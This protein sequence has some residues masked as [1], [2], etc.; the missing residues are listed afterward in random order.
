MGKGRFPKKKA[1]LL[2]DFLQKRRWGLA[3]AFFGRPSL[4]LNANF[5][6]AIGQKKPAA[7]RENGAMIIC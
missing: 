7:K 3:A 1:A 4:R 5:G 6:I 2:L